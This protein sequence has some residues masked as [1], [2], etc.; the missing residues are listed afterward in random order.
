MKPL[1]KV[2]V[3]TMALILVLAVF[4]LA[5]TLL[6]GLI[7]LIISVFDKAGAVPF[8]KWGVLVL[9]IIEGLFIVPAA[10][11]SYKEGDY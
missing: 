8:F 10:V 7:S 11:K 9:F 1:K 2:F 3:I 5:D 6:I 4:L